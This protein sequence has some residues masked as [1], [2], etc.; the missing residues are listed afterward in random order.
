MVESLFDDGI[1]TDLRPMA[2]AG[3]RYAY[4]NRS[5]RPA[6]A[7]IRALLDRWFLHYAATERP[8]LAAKF[9]AAFDAAFFELALHELLQRLGCAVEVHPS[10]AGTWKR[11]DYL[12][13]PSDGSEP[14][15]LEAVLVTDESAED[16][17]HRRVRHEVLDAINAFFN[18]NFF[19][20]IAKLAGKATSPPPRRALHQYLAALVRG[21]DPD[22]VAADYERGGF[23]ALPRARLEHAGLVLEMYPVPKTTHARGDRSFRSVGV[24]PVEMAWLDSGAA[25]RAAVKRKAG[26]YGT[27]P[28]PF[29]IAVNG[30]TQWGIK[31]D[32]VMAALFGPEDVVYRA[33][34]PVFA[35]NGH[36]AFVH[37]GRPTNTRVSGVLV[38][39]ELHP[40]SL[41]TAPLR[42]Y[43]HPWASR[44]ADGAIARLPQ[45]RLDDARLRFEDGEDGTTLFGVPSDWPNS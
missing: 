21:L 37:Q 30:I 22:V 28:H 38:A 18:P 2:H 6:V 35:H 7:N 16:A 42:L 5:A 36:G 33:G 45:A 17:G 14:F 32:D 39:M 13:T 23:D 15:F 20:G 25:I 27:L 41:A 43:H 10:V 19:F 12:A 40:S 1:R 11:P 34:E 3:D 31:H 26:R 9:R 4:Y 44:P 8:E 24:G 29:I